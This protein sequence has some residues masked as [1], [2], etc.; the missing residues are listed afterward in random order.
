[1]ETELEQTSQSVLIAELKTLVG[2]PARVTLSD[3]RTPDGTVKVP[4][5]I[6]AVTH[7]GVTVD[8]FF[9]L[10]TPRLGAP[11]V[12]EVMARAALFQG[13]TVVQQ[14]ANP[15]CLRLI[16][17]D[18]L[19]PIQRRR[20]PRVSVTVPA[21]LGGDSLPT[22]VSGTIT[23]LSAGGCGIIVQEQISIGALVKVDLEAI[24]LTPA[25]VWAHVV[26][27]SLCTSPNGQWETGLAFI[28]LTQTQTAHLI[29]FVE[30]NT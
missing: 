19:H 2:C 18:R 13:F 26:R 16:L 28:N 7:E 30:H 21:V 27:C 5:T 6:R 25:E 14:S 12:L 20:F 10:L 8:L 17:P 11:V 1:M 3:P 9:P 22:N 4:G 23:N 29:R 15:Q 24:G